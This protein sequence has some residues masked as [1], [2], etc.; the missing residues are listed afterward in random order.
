MPDSSASERI[1]TARAI[2]EALVGIPIVVT[3]QVVQNVGDLRLND[4][5]TVAQRVA[6]LRSL[7]EM[8]VKVGVRQA[9][10]RFGRS[11]P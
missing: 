1:A 8:V 9:R 11:R 5:T 3:Q 7:G 4:E 2:A 6:Q 10:S